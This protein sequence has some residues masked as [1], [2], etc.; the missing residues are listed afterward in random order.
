MTVQPLRLLAQD[1]DDL[2]LIS[3]ALQDGVVK[4][5]D[6]SYAPATRTLTFPLSRFRWEAEEPSRA[7]AA[8]QFGDVLE[9]K[10]RGLPVDR[11]ASCSLLAIEFTPS[12]D[13]PGGELMLRF[14]GCGDLKVRV[15][16]VDCALVDLGV[17]EPAES[18]PQHVDDL[19]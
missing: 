18:I 3:A 4:L 1:E 13:P 14:A 15:E 8:V 12:D 2:L 9:V 5:A 10:A 6:I 16:C 19:L 7:E 17:P 11:D